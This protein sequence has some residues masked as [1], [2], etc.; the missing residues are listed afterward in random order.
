VLLGV[1]FLILGFIYG[2]NV[3]M[4]IIFMIGIIVANVPEGLLVTVT[5]C[6]ALTAR[7]M[8]E[9]KVLVKN[10]ESVE[11]L[12]STTCICSDKTGTLTQ[13][14]MT[15]SHLFY[16][17]GMVD[18]STNYEDCKGNPDLKVGYNPKDP[19]F[20]TLMET[21]ALGTKATFSYAP[22][23]AEMKK[24]LAIQ[25][26][27]KISSYKDYQMSEAE[28]KLAADALMSVEK[29]KP[30]SMRSTAGDASESGLI[31]FVQGL[32]DIE[33]YRK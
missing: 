5:V 32:F 17:L 30:L 25:H 6:L 31:K 12:G 1:S 19:M 22:T 13:N 21:V 10:M 18:A 11:T 16:N 7:R 33:E 26:G 15:M 14:K 8:A 3:V 20:Q 4:N 28:K 23:D 9:K 27:K 24:F 29:E 2:Y